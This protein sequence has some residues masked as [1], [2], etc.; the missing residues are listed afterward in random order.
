[1]ANRNL[2]AAWKMLSS[3][4]AG[5]VLTSD[6]NG[7][8]T[9]QYG[10]RSPRTP[11]V[12]PVVV[13]TSVT[14]LD[15][16]G[17]LPFPANA[18][19]GTTILATVR[20]TNAATAQIFTARVLFGPTNTNTDAQVASASF[21]AGTAVIGGATLFISFTLLTATTAMA[22]ILLTSGGGITASGTAAQNSAGAITVA[23][24]APQFLGIYG[25]STVSTIVTSRAVTWQTITQ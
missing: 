10:V 22:S 8:G 4:A 16:A 23:T 19:V 25:S 2:A 12:T 13:L 14:N 7:V 9:W 5:K 11:S 18:T 3:A 21:A 6:A 20:L 24:A 15:S 17:G 1:M